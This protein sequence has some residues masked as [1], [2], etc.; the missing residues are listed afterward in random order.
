[1]HGRLGRCSLSRGSAN[2]NSSYVARTR[3]SSLHVTVLSDFLIFQS[4][5]KA[6]DRF[7]LQEM[8]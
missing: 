6:W 3:P 1:M 2:H 7:N 8:G 5:L 4:R